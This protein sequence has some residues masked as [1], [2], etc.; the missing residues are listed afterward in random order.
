MVD[1]GSRDGTRRVIFDYIRRHGL[2]A[3][4]LLQ[5]PANLGKVRVAF[6]IF[7]WSVSVLFGTC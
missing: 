2:D 6:C 7:L 3:V 5:Q 1:D 4:R